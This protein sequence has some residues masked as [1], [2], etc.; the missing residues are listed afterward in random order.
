LPTRR[1]FLAGLGATT[2]AAPFTRLLSGTARADG[3]ARRL[4]VFATPN[5]TMPS[6]LWPTGGTTDFTFGAGTALEPLAPIQDKV[7]VIR[8]LNFHNATNH[9]GGMASMLT[10]GGG[11]GTA[12]GGMSLDQV[13]AAQ[14]GGATRFPS[15]ELG[16]QTSAWGGSSQ[17]RMSYLGPG[18]YVTPDD[19]P[20]NVYQRMFGDVLG[21]E[22]EAA[23]LRARRGSVLDVVSGELGDLRSRVGAEERIKLD[24]HLNAIA[25]MEQAL[26]T[27]TTCEPGVGPEVPGGVLNNE[28]FPAIGAAHM[29]LAVSALACGMTNVVSL[30]WA[31]TVS[32]VVFSW[33]GIS[34]GHHSLSH[35][36]DG[37]TE[38]VDNY[39][40]AERWFAERFTELVQALDAMPDPEGGGSLLDSTVV[41]WTQEMGDGRLHVCEDVPFVLAGA[42]DCFTPGRY[43]QLGSRNHAGLL[44]S[45]ANAFGLGLDTFGDPGAGSGGIEELA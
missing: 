19:N 40:A 1:Q 36:D 41:L 42:P 15:L 5:G 25:S 8:G 22:E 12:T 43:L 2:L 10:N 37:N 18:Q 23:L 4:I 7:T 11:V 6:R 33:L 3:L 30:Q 27:T 44:V 16:V 34:E 38:G 13:V 32:P 29:D 39:I 14:I 17:T 24:V 9:E 28:N 45:V 21:G 35:T 20:V 31:H 26:D